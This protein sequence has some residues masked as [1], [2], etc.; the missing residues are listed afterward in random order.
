MIRRRRRRRACRPTP[1]LRRL[2]RGGVG[3]PSP[4]ERVAAGY[5]LNVG[6]DRLDLSE[7]GDSARR[8]Q[9]AREDG[10]W[11]EALAAAEEATQLW[12][13]DL[14][15]GAV[16][17]AGWLGAHAVALAETAGAVGDI[18]IS[19][20][21]ARGDTGAA[22][23]QIAAVRA[24]DPFGER[25]AWLHMVA[26]YQAGR[27]AEALDV[28]TAHQRRIDE[29][30]GLDPGAELV[31][32]HSAVL[33]HDPVIAAWPRTLHWSGAVAVSPVDVSSSLD[34]GPS[35]V[36]VDRGTAPAGSV[37]LVGRDEQLSQLGALVTG[38]GTRWTVLTGPA[39][40]GKTRLAQAAA[41]L[42]AQDGQT[43][44]WV[45][46]PTRRAPR[47]VA[48]APTVPRPRRRSRTMCSPYPP[49]RVRTRPGSSSTSVC[50]TSLPTGPSG[51]LSRSSSTMRSGP[52]R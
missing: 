28:Y 36:A 27:A 13:G 7:F 3:D 37:P 5:R 12:R 23:A 17:Q 32:L 40:I 16:E 30:L 49:A 41:A 33:R 26:L 15:G 46:C 21:L 8:A 9:A 14:L 48:A 44:V 6:E 45:R 24:A 22:L 50:S 19:A 29:E 2:P 4:I 11:D 1:N 31:A 25:A 52:T 43:V 42:A 38:P 18:R 10:R 47:L 20:L 35:G 39:G 34:D 51:G